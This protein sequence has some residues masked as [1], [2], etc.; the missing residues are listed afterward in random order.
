[1][2]NF[3]RKI[4]KPKEALWKGVFCSSTLGKTPGSQYLKLLTLLY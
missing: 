3:L 2:E 1:M 4:Y